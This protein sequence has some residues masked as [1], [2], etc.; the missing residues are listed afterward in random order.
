MH[1]AV[2]TGKAQLC[3]LLIEEGADIDVV[4][5][6]GQ[7][8]LMHAVICENKEVRLSRFLFVSVFHTFT[9]VDCWP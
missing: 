7:T 6:V 9:F 1:R 3:E 2:G 8:P 4:D 5:R